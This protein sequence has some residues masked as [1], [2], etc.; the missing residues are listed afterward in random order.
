MWESLR[1]E[2]KICFVKFFRKSSESVLLCKTDSYW[3][4]LHCFYCSWRLLFGR[5]TQ[6]FWASVVRGC[7]LLLFLFVQLSTSYSLI[8]DPDPNNRTI[9]RLPTSR[10]WSK[11]LP[12]ERENTDAL[13]FLAAMVFPSMTHCSYPGGSLQIT[14]CWQ[15]SPDWALKRED[16]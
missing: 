3:H 13:P 1:R 12:V 7:T 16:T 4:A 11:D 8:K 5:T 2:T 10:A 9:N 15:P 14:V 6:H